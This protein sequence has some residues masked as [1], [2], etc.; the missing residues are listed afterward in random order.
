[1]PG[2][3]TIERRPKFLMPIFFGRQ[4]APLIATAQSSH[5]RRAFT[6]KVANWV[7]RVARSVSAI[8]TCY[9]KRLTA[10]FIPPGNVMRFFQGALHSS[11]LNETCYSHAIE[12][13][14]AELLTNSDG[15]Y[16]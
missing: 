5:S 6:G 14:S 13:R 11:T 7:A 15:A 4:F 16:Y 12:N 2:N 10:A 8:F 3:V 9:A 1:M